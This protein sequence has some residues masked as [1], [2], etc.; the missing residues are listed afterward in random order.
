MKRMANKSD[1]KNT[2]NFLI[3]EKQKFITWQNILLTVV[4]QSYNYFFH[5]P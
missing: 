4:G 5:A 2:I 3:D 1:I